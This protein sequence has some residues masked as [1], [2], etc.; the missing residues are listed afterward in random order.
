MTDF[1]KAKRFLEEYEVLC[2]AYGLSIETDNDVL[3][4]EP[5]DFEKVQDEIAD[6]LDCAKQR[7]IP[8]ETEKR[9]RERMK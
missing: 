9:F 7:F 6:L 4:V 3:H 2:L 8:G 5:S 1:E